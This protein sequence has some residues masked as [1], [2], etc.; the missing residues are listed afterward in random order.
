[1][2]RISPSLVISVIA[3]FVAL[4]GTGYAISQLPADSFTT[5]RVKNRP[6][7]AKDLKKGEIPKGPKGAIGATGATGG[8]GADG[9]AKVCAYIEDLGSGVNAV[10]AKSKGI[11]SSTLCRP[12]TGVYC[13]ERSS[14][15]A[16]G[17][18]SASVETNFNSIPESDKVASL[19]LLTNSDFGFGCPSDSHMVVPI[20]DLSSAA[21][22]NWLFH[23]TL[24]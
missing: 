3:L 13:F 1:M 16:L 17:N 7:L 19:Q 10:P 9:S 18:A 11:T 15:G 21:L 20:R 12:Q 6:L 23:V 24:N 14:L 4:G 2:E 5:K 22:T 8:T